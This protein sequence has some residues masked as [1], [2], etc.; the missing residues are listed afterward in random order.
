MEAKRQRLDERRRNGDQMEAKTDRVMETRRC[1]RVMESENAGRQRDDSRVSAG[2][3]G[4]EAEREDG[5][6]EETLG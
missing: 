6:R 4:E 5:V 2:W 1:S 3:G